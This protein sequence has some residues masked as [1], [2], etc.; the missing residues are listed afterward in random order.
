VLFF[1]TGA[2]VANDYEANRIIFVWQRQFDRRGCGRVAPRSRMGIL[3][4]VGAAES[5][6]NR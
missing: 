1:G 3:L 4:R 6:K 2:G 5:Q